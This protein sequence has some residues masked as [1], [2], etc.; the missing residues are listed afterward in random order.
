MRYLLTGDYRSR[1]Q[2][3]LSLFNVSIVILVFFIFILL[4]VVSKHESNYYNFTLPHPKII[5]FSAATHVNANLDSLECT[6]K[7]TSTSVHLILV[8]TVVFAST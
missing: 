4:D 3:M 2:I 5:L 7:Q 1:L 8:Q 6:A